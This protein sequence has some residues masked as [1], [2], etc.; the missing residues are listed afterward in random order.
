VV[1]QA[2]GLGAEVGARKA[3]LLHLGEA[4]LDGHVLDLT[5]VL[6]LVVAQGAILVTADGGPTVGDG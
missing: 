1:G 6:D 4:V 2:G 5:E 3:G